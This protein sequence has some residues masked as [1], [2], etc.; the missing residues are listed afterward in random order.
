MKSANSWSAETRCGASAVMR[1]A[2]AQHA[3]PWP[4]HRAPV[5]SKYRWI[6]KDLACDN[7]RVSVRLLFVT[8][9][10][11]IDRV[12]LAASGV[13]V[14]GRPGHPLKLDLS[15]V[16]GPPPVAQCR[17]RQVEQLWI[18]ENTGAEGQTFH[19]GEPIN[20]R[21]ELGTWDEIR[22]GSQLFW[23][24]NR[25]VKSQPGDSAPLRGQLDELKK[26]LALA[27]Q[28]AALREA[29]NQRLATKLQ[30]AEA[31]L[32][33]QGEGDTLQRRKLSDLQQ[34]Y[35]ASRARTEEL[36]RQHATE[37]SKLVATSRQI[38]EELT[39]AQ[40]HIAQLD[41]A[42]AGA[43]TG[44][45]QASGKLHETEAVVRNLQQKVQDTVSQLAAAK[46]LQE[47][48]SLATK[49]QLEEIERL[50][51]AAEVKERSLQEARASRAEVEKVIRDLRDRCEKLQ[52]GQQERDALH[53]QAARAR[54][55]LVECQAKLRRFEAEAESVKQQSRADEPATAITNQHRQAVKALDRAIVDT[56]YAMSKCEEK[57]SRSIDELSK[58]QQRQE[59][60]RELR[61]V[62]MM[63]STVCACLD[64]LQRLLPRN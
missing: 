13:K 47:E 51:R 61:Q 18:V 44:F 64:Q 57:W 16:N 32:R 27:D 53:I 48:L 43:E 8:K 36:E 59:L 11:E 29:D 63:I 6:S 31:R 35:D 4:D 22:C 46:A 3:L 38:G 39:R 23:F 41:L 54:R 7:H 10:S 33:E 49:T 52:H 12:E 14:Y 56:N 37:K 58:P 34:Q 50:E 62:S 42:R 21:A 45:H 24:E 26:A 17:I 28:R 1:F 2:G 30:E 19:N 9:H 15:E 55:A 40:R 25:T 60:V 5:H 20:R